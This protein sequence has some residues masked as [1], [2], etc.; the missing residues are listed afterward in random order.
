MSSEPV[1]G[2]LLIPRIIA[3]L[4][5]LPLTAVTFLVVRT[6]LLSDKV[7]LLA[8]GFDLSFAAAAALCWWFALRGHVSSNRVI[9]LF[10]LI[11]A[12]IVGGIGFVIG[13]FGP[14]IFT[15]RSNQGPLLGIF[16]TGPLGFAIG[17][18]LGAAAGLIR[19][20]FHASPDY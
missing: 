1:R 3:A 12:F 4:L 2:S 20:C 11:G 5:A 19:I 8:I 14:M 17:A 7:N 10:A 15:P 13:F 18:L 9:M 16:F 6:T